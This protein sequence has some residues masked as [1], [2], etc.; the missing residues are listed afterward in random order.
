MKKIPIVDESCVVI[1]TLFGI[2]YAPLLSG[3]LASVAAVIAFL[4][5]KVRV[6]FIIFTA[7]SIWLSFLVAGRAEKIFEEKDS[8]KI[9]IDD[10]SGML[11]ALLFVPYDIK[12][13]VCAFILFRVFDAFKIPPI[14]KIERLKGATGVVGDDLMAGF[15]S[16]VA[17]Q[18][19][20]L[21]VR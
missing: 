4:L 14:D 10:F 9:V 3:T 19:V 21:F 6:Y 17:L 15:Y 7:I 5:I 8:K 18:I 13:V 16:L 2:G 1:A 12:F 20:R 11:L